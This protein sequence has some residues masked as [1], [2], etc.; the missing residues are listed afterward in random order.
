MGWV[1]DVK[2][3]SRMDRIMK[4]VLCVV[5]AGIFVAVV[6]C[7]EKGWES[8]YGETVA[9]LN[10]ADLLSKGEPYLEEKVTVKG[11]VERIDLSRPGNALVVLEGGIICNLG[12]LEA[13][14]KSAS[15]GQ[16]VYIDGFLMKCAAGDIL[17]EPAMLRDPSAPFRPE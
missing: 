15:P 14:A 5:V 3:R 17:F 7:G 8:E 9:H 10:A 11:K 2:R 1:N 6:G 16:I 12:E 4:F 13:M